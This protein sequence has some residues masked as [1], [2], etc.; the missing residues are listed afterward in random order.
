[1]RGGSCAGEHHRFRQ[2]G[3]HVGG[4]FK[5]RTALAREYEGRL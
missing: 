5:K 1:M 2:V 4:V 3:E